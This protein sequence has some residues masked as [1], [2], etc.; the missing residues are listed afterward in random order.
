MAITSNLYN[1]CLRRRCVTK[2]GK[3]AQVDFI[4]IDNQRPHY[5]ECRLGL[6]IWGHHFS[7]SVAWGKAGKKLKNKQTYNTQYNIY[8]WHPPPTLTFC[9]TLSTSDFSERTNIGIPR[10]SLISPLPG[11]FHVVFL[12]LP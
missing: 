8:L 1:E 12:Q 11:G 3:V 10:S 5:L 4:I 6:G 7:L 2:K 9:K